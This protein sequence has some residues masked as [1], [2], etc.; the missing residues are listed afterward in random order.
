MAI[1]GSKTDFGKRLGSNEK[2]V[3]DKATDTLLAWL[4][5]P[6]DMSEDDMVKVWEG[7]F[8]CVWMADKPLVQQELTERLASA[9][10]TVDRSLV[11]PYILGFWRVMEQSWLK[12][13]KHRVN[14]FL[15]LVRFMIR[16][17]FLVLEKFQWEAKLVAEYNSA[18]SHT[19]LDL[20]SLKLPLG[21]TSQ[22][23]ECFLAEL[24]QIP[25]EKREPIPFTSLMTPFVSYLGQICDSLFSKVIIKRVFKLLFEQRDSADY[26]EEYPYYDRE[27]A[28]LKDLLFTE[29]A[30]EHTR[31][32]CRKVLYNL[33]SRLEAFYPAEA[34]TIGTKRKAEATKVSSTATPLTKTKS[35]KAAATPTEA[36][37]ATNE[38]PTKRAKSSARATASSTPTVI[39]APIAESQKATKVSNGLANDSSAM[40]PTQITN[41]QLFLR[42]QILL[43]KKRR[44]DAQW[45]VVEQQA[46]TR[47][48]APKPR[49]SSSAS[50]TSTPVASTAT[51]ETK[52]AKKSTPTSSI[53]K[54][55][56]DAQT[57]VTTAFTTK[58]KVTPTP[59]TSTTATVT[60]TATT[61]GT[62]TT[63]T[64]KK[65][66]Q[67]SMQSNLVKR[68]HKKLPVTP[69]PTAVKFG[70]PTKSALRSAD[71]SGSP[72]AHGGQSPSVSGSPT[73]RSTL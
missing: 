72:R 29:G 45:L 32:P 9:L 22:Y 48:T 15:L 54:K 10:L 26:S 64:G 16:Y 69:I 56:E 36:A 13:D 40:L 50:K 39:V 30:K 60:A 24:D 2:I 5:A 55:S 21:L 59:T 57:P 52:A 71:W 58:S 37:P 62:S 34:P 8:Y 61:N 66:V 6:R 63:P 70:T 3:R 44:A 12:I 25:L 31:S 18:M 46:P 35:K 17:S 27:L 23:C 73:P 43:A 7:L 53:L 68:F 1:H 38:Q 33:S 41:P 51:K 49:G 67:W 28:L 14:K 19:I 4:A 47:R 20:A 42:K 11:I 65:Q